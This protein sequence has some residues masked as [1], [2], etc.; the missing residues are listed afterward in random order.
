MRYSC[1]TL[2]EESRNRFQILAL[3]GGGIRG[4]F[5][6]ATLAAL[7]EDLGTRVVEHFDLIVGTSTGGIIALGLGAGLS[8]AEILEFYV[9]RQRQIFPRWPGRGIR[10]CV[11]AKYSP[12]PLEAALKE[13]LGE[14][15][16]ADSSK[17]LVVTSYDVGH[18]G[19]HLFK[20]P[21]HPRLRRDYRVPMWQVGMATA[22]APTYFPAFRLPSEERLIDGGVWA[23]NPAMVGIAEAVSMFGRPLEQLRLLNLG[24]TSSETVR[25]RGL[26][27]GGIA[28]WVGGPGAIETLMRGQSIG[29]FN[30]AA[31][32]IGPVAAHRLDPTSP[33]QAELDRCDARDLIGK[34]SR[35]SR[36]FAPTFE[37]V[38]AGHAPANYEPMQKV[39]PA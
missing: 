19:V 17:P 31:H 18:N 37:Q 24:T 10:R 3:D 25:R 33:R 39:R 1:A 34:A 21:H 9:D 32:L 38:F 28:Q 13:I 16:L 7:E 26:D 6:A 20:T 29:A 15:T 23:N 35:A 30:Q 27:A 5:S 2:A 22:A 8:P 11:S 4:I 14:R 36:H 12:K